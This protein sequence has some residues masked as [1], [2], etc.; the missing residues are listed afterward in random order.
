M[1]F[2]KIKPYILNNQ[3][4]EQRD[5]NWCGIIFKR[6]IAQPG[7]NVYRSFPISEEWTDPETKEV[8]TFKCSNSSCEVGF[9]IIS[10]EPD[11]LEAL[12]NELRWFYNGRYE[13]T[14]N[15]NKLP[16]FKL[17]IG[18]ITYGEWTHYNS[19]EFGQLCSIGMSC[20]LNYPIL[21][22][23]NDVGLIKK[24]NYYLYKELPENV[25]YSSSLIA[26]DDGSIDIVS[27]AI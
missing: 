27:P 13:Y 9:D 5:D 15:L 16:D 19:K 8:H 21:L 23:N 6:E 4:K 3:S 20:V 17:D 22:K 10:N 7:Q 12:E 24:I 11:H 25:I 1:D 2:S 14:I 26:K 18:S